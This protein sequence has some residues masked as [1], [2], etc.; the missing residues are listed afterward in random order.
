MPSTTTTRSTGSVCARRLASARP[1]VGS[2]SV[3]TAAETSLI[4]SFLVKHRVRVQGPAGAARHSTPSMSTERR[5]HPLFVRSRADA[6]WTGREV[7]LLRRRAFL[8]RRAPQQRGPCARCAASPL[9]ARSGHN[10]Q[11]C[12]RT[13]AS[14]GPGN[15]T[16][17]L[18]CWRPSASLSRDGAVQGFRV[19]QSTLCDRCA[20]VIRCSFREFSGIQRARG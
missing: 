2:P 13:G 11:P 20:T 19:R 7:G 5:R 9:L 16:A 3:R 17:G 1:V 12:V 15:R 18:R 8:P 14:G 4:E 6:R 10:G